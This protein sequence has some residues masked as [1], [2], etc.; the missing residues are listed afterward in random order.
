MGMDYMNRGILEVLCGNGLCEQG[1]F[2][3]PFVGMGYRSK[4][5]FLRPLVGISHK[6]KGLS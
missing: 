4:G 5:P 6:S 3:G 1:S 2:L